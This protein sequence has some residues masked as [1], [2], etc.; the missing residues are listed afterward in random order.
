MISFAFPWAVLFLPLP[1]LLLWVLPVKEQ[2]SGALTLPPALGAALKPAQ[3]QITVQRASRVA[4]MLIWVLSV[5]ALMGP[6]REQVLDVLPASGRDLL[7]SLDLSGSMEREDFTLNGEV[8]SR[9]AAVQA[10]AS[11]FVRGRL[12]DSVGLV[13]FGD[14]AYVAAAPTHDVAS[15]AHVIETTMI[16]VSGKSTAIADGIGLAIKRL[17]ERDA[18]SRVIIL[19][20]DGQD[21]SGSTDPLAAADIAAR[22]GIRIYTIALGPADLESDP[23]SRDA[24][25]AAMLSDIAHAA[26]G[27]MFRVRNTEDLRT[28]TDA[29]DALEPSP[30]K[31]PP[32]ETWREFWMWP[33]GLALF[34]VAA[35]LLL[36]R[37]E[38]RI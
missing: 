1:L 22:Y 24:V 20:S 5:L 12:G 4:L 13:V 37:G 29:I 3:A 32:I 6:R 23:S 9:L 28:V 2:P 35:L 33:G 34:L 38:V 31:A 19:L 15:V 14:R 18:K 30:S 16:G 25:D 36:W 10:V 26:N 21:T 11:E 8:V 7:L 17:R 27:Q